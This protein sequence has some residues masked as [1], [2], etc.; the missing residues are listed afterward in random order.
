MDERKKKFLK[1]F[2]QKIQDARRKQNISQEMLASKAEIERSYMGRI[3]RAESNPP[4]YTV[5]KILQALN[6]PAS[7][8]GL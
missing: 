4:I 1:S 7:D 5:H 6:V 3:E 8:L 2:G